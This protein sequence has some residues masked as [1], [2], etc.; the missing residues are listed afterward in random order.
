MDSKTKNGLI[1]LGVVVVLGVVAIKFMKMK[2]QPPSDGDGN[3]GGGGGDNSGGG[4]GGNSGGGGQQSLSYRSLADAL[5]EAMDGY[6]TN[7]DDIMGVFKNL[8]NQADFDALEQ[9]FGSREI[10]SGAGNIFSSNYKGRLVGA[11]KD[12]LDSSELADLN[13]LLRSKKIKAI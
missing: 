10:S 13:S 4:G 12:E 9:A 5:F 6:G 11:L 3:N 2:Q 7:E 8:R 1:V